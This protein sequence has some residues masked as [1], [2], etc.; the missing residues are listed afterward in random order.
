MKRSSDRQIAVPKNRAA[1]ALSE[2]QF[3]LNV[4]KNKRQYSRKTKFKKGH[5]D[6]YQN[7]PFLLAG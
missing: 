4:V 6:Q 7:V 2:T 5:L 1:K 3:K